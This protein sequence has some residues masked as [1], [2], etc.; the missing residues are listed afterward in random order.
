M[1]CDAQH[2]VLSNAA[3]RFKRP[4]ILDV[5]LGTVLYDEDATEEKKAR[6]TQRALDTTSGT[7]G[8]RLTGFQ[9]RFPSLRRLL[10]TVA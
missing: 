8:I 6:M 7:T 10:K 2:I 5:K 9:V 3:S 1:V 4:S